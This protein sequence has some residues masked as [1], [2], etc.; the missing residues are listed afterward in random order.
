M[1]FHYNNCQGDLEQKTILKSRGRTLG[2]TS[3]LSKWHQNK[4]E[5]LTPAV[6]VR[7]PFQ[8]QDFTPGMQT[9][10]NRLKVD[11]FIN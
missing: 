6:T 7:G 8:E 9:L 3:V 2:L 11:P 5:A 1:E 10:H 4:T